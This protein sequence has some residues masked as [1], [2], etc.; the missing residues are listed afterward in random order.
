VM[1]G[2]VVPPGA[3]EIVWSYAVPG[4]R[5]GAIASGA[6]L[7]LLAAT[8]VGLAIRRVRAPILRA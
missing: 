6:T 4:L 7:L 1:R 2:V 8:A 5:L 3:H